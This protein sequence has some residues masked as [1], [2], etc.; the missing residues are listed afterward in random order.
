MRQQGVAVAFAT[1]MYTGL[2]DEASVGLMRHTRAASPYAME[3]LFTHLLL[4]F[5][6]LG[7]RSFS[8]GMAPLAGV[9]RRPLSSGWHWLGALIWRHG[10]PIYNFQGLRVFKGKFNPSWEP[11]YLAASGTLGPFV[12]LLDVA[13]LIAARYRGFRKVLRHGHPD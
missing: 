8:L 1:V 12:A 6:D 7:Y 10:N 9:Q 4:A 13:G 11:R 3:F 5:R 2:R